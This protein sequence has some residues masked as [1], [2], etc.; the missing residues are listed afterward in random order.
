M[1]T[2]LLLLRHGE[3]VA[4]AQK[5]FASHLSYPL[6]E[7]GHEQAELTAQ[8]LKN[9]KIDCIY[10]SDL[11]RA[12]E[13]AEHIA[14]YHSLQI[15]THTGLREVFAGQWEGITFPE[16]ARLYP[17]DFTVWLENI[18]LC[19][20]TGGESI[21][22]LQQRGICTIAEIVRENPGK[23]VCVSTHATFLRAMQCY[24]EAKPLEAMKDVP[25]AANASIL[26]VCYEEDLSFH[27]FHTGEHSH[28]GKDFVTV[29][30]HR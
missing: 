22:A 15:R 12:M 25:W 6:T 29:P 5:I 4:N 8:F 17:A 18:G 14:R 20:P 2:K 1:T 21:A 27:D 26:S 16:I 10:S 30:V 19:C 7:K 28:L 24:W 3:S 13:T 9:E 11:P 23:T